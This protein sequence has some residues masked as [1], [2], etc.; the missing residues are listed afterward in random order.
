MLQTFYL[1]LEI[2]SK[3]GNWSFNLTFLCSQCGI[4]C[5]L[6]DFLTAGE[7]NS[8]PTEHTEIHAKVRALYNYLGKIWEEDE[9]KYET[10][11]TNTPCPFLCNKTCS[12]YPIRPEGCRQFPN[13]IFGMQTQDCEALTRFKK[14]LNALKKNRASRETYISTNAKE[15]IIPSNFTQKQYQTCLS[16]LRK[17]GITKDE[18][19]LFHRLNKQN[20]ML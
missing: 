8:K 12:I 19:N 10:Y 5:T 2:K 6:D 14:Q 11:V 4:C 3:R 1:H 13:T 20:K 18:L 16:R 15:S 9:S 17:A 7:L